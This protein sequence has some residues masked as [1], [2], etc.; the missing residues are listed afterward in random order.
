M[1]ALF[2][3]SPVVQRLQDILKRASLLTICVCVMTFVS[4]EYNA[5]ISFLISGCH[6]Y[7]NIV[8]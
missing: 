8:F 1:N 2:F 6:T 4:F 7:V 3:I 5:A